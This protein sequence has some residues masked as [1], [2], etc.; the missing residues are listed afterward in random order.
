MA[1]SYRNR[2]KGHEKEIRDDLALLGES[3]TAEKWGAITFGAFHEYATE[4]LGRPPEYV[5]KFA[6]S[7]AFQMAHY[8]VADILARL[9]EK[10]ERIEQL[11]REIAALHDQHLLEQKRVKMSGVE[12]MKYLHQV[13]V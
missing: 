3:P 11:T 4:L 8:L 6:H 13:K 7:D 2:F 9:K 12:M 1:Q 10:D 5:T